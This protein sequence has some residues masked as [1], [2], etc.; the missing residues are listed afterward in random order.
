L[1]SNGR[2][3]QKKGRFD[4]SEESLTKAVSDLARK[5]FTLILEDPCQIVNGTLEEKEWYPST[6]TISL[7]KVGFESS[8][9][10]TINVTPTHRGIHQSF[11]NQFKEFEISKF[12]CSHTEYFYKQEVQKLVT[13]FLSQYASINSEKTFSISSIILK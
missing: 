11:M 4:L 6:I 7:I 3:D 12:V 2:V 10:T 8:E 1:N 5:N 9:R 13:R